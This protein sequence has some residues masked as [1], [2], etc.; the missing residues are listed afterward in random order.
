MA[1]KITIE[2]LDS[3]RFHDF[4]SN[5][6]MELDQVLDIDEKGI[7]LKAFNQSKTNIIFRKFSFN[8]EVKIKGK[9]SHFKFFLQNYSLLQKVTG[10]MR[11]SSTLKLTL[12]CEEDICKKFTISNDYINYDFVAGTF[13]LANYLPDEVWSKN[14]SEPKGVTAR[15]D[16]TSNKILEIISLHKIS[17][18]DTERMDVMTIFKNDD[19]NLVFRHKNHAKT[20]DFIFTEEQGLKFCDLEGK[21]TLSL[22]VFRGYKSYSEFELHFSE[23]ENG[24]KMA[25][26]VNQDNFTNV[27]SLTDVD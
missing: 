7:H 6:F 2:G 15:I 25:Y 17:K 21:L 3:Q 8:E 14:F 9:M 10:W 1:N 18:S 11:G 12:T 20:L 26:L 19:G 27:S 4:C 23:N 13:E 16:I 22:D 5:S 24:M